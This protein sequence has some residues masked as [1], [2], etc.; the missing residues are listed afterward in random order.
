MAWFYKM[1]GDADLVEQQ[2]PAF[3]EFLKSVKFQLPAA[4]AGGNA[5][6]TS[7]QPAVT[8]ARPPPPPGR[9]HRE[10][11]PDWKVPAGWQEVAGGQFLVAKFNIPG[12]GGGTAAATSACPPVKAAG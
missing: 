4:H 5:G 7:V 6:G 1:T 8:W 10:G 12:N 11:Q 2:K 9:F 3:I